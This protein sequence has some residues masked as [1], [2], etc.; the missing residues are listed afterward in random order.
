MNC[1]VQAL[2]ST[3]AAA[4]LLGWPASIYLLSNAR[5]KT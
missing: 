1:G 3:D 4:R 2:V 5:G